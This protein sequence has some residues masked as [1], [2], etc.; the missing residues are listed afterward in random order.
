MGMLV[1]RPA[2]SALKQ[3]WNHLLLLL[4][5]GMSALHLLHAARVVFHVV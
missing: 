4:F 1:G 5:Q 3:C 2:A